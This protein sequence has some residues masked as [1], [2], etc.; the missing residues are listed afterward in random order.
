MKK[1]IILSF[2]IISLPKSWA[3]GPKG[4]RIVGTIAQNNLESKAKKLVDDLLP[5][6]NLAMVSVWA[7]DL[8]SDPKFDHLRTWHYAT[9]KLDQKE[10]I[11]SDEDGRL[12]WA[13]EHNINILKDKNAE[14]NKKTDALKWLVHLVGDLH[15]PLHVGTQNDKGGG[16]CT[17]YF[18]G[19][20]TNLHHLWDHD[21]IEFTGLS[22]T[23]FVDFLNPNLAKIKDET[24]H[25]KS[26]LTW[27][28]ESRSINQNIYPDVV[29]EKKFN[30]NGVRAYCKLS[31]KNLSQNQLPALSYE[32][33]YQYLS[34]AKERLALAGKRLALIL[35]SI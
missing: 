7:D 6:E 5:L 9:W 23:E 19:N 28:N 35:N 8:K 30:I 4:H 18:H 31:S 26:L 24:Y 10:P 14:K 25:E 13:I 15:M 22:F 32:Y 16:N 27:A 29:G 21:L 11:P 17:V 1:I 3:W 33:S 34:I 12:I 20:K 2:F